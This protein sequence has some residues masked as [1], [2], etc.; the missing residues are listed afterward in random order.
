ME[1]YTLEDIERILNDIN[2]EIDKNGDVYKEEYNNG[3]WT[4]TTENFTVMMGWDGY[5]Q[6]QQVLLN[7]LK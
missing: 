4:I 7:K 2:V 5:M 6:L 3:L 1:K